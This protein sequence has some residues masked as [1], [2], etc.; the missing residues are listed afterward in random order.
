MRTVLIGEIPLE[1]LSPETVDAIT[2]VKAAVWSELAPN[3]PV[4]STNA[5]LSDLRNIPANS[6]EQHLLARVDDD[7]A[8]LASI[9]HSLSGAN[10]AV[11]TVMIEVRAEY[12]RRGIARA[13]LQQMVSLAR[14]NG[15]ESLVSWGPRT[16]ATQQFWKTFGLP[17]V[18]STSRHR[19]S[20]AGID[21]PLLAQWCQAPTARQRGYTV[22]H[23]EGPCPDDLLSQFIATQ[24]GMQDAPTDGLDMA[25]DPIDVAQ[26]RAY[27][28]RL[29]E[30]GG[31][32]H[33]VLAIDPNGE[34]AGVSEV[35]AF[36]H[37]PHIVF[38]Q[39]TATLSAHRRCGLGRWL[40]G[41]MYQHILDRLPHAAIIETGNADS[42][43]SMLAINRQM[44]FE[45]FLSYSIG[46]GRIEEIQARLS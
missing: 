41:E 15:C 3:D 36:D 32:A 40:K 16:S 46:Q 27:E 45:P 2:A 34:G 31:T 26:V 43:T 33:V 19:A 7:V 24:N 6:V 37:T 4:L 8:G 44:G 10:A 21:A 1:S 22:R 11:A 17:E 29:A 39:T 38:Q 9:H 28:S 20:I 42:N 5:A 30:R 14:A 13:L 23:F 35:V 12:R 25:F 18:Q